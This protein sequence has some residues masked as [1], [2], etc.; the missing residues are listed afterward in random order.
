MT[1]SAFELLPVTVSKPDL[2]LVIAVLEDELGPWPE[3]TARR[4]DQAHAR[5]RAVAAWVLRHTPGLDLSLH[6]IGQLLGGLDHTSVMHLIEKVEVHPFLSERARA[7]LARVEMQLGRRRNGALLD[8]V[9]RVVRR[10]FGLWELDIRR[11]RQ[12]MDA[13]AAGAVAALILEGLGFGPEDA[14]RVWGIPESVYRDLLEWG[15]ADAA[16]A[17]LAKKLSAEVR[18]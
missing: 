6:L 10:A 18:R 9:G 13:P 14:C 12:L 7:I 15:H 5:A 1:L 16:L 11:C 2:E 8:E 3:L 17:A 4:R